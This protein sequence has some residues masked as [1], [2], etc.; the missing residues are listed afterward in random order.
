[1]LCALDVGICSAMPDSS[2]FCIPANM[3]AC[4]LPF[5]PTE[6]GEEGDSSKTSCW[7]EGAWPFCIVY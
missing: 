6:E 7:S 3:T 4:H 2:V 5:S 1:M